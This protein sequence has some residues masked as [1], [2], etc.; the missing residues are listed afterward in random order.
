MSYLF[1][2]GK[3]DKKKIPKTIMLFHSKMKRL[4]KMH[5]YVVGYNSVHKQYAYQIKEKL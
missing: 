4:D 2:K 1:P 5:R 3:K